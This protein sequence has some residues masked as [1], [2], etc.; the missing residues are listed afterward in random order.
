[1]CKFRQKYKGSIKYVYV[2][3][4]YLNFRSNINY[5]KKDILESI[6]NLNLYFEILYKYNL[7]SKNQLRYI[8]KMYTS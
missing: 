8:L 1:M 4:I 2:I 3:I 6:E 5:N 7:F